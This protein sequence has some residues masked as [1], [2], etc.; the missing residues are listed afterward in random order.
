MN[1]AHLNH[2]RVCVQS[3]CVVVQAIE[4][5]VV[6]QTIEEFVVGV[7]HRAKV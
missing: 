4:A 7:V 1:K 5:C 3:E 2:Q 6:I